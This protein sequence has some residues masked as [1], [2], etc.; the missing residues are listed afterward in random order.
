MKNMVVDDRLGIPDTSADPGSRLLRGEEVAQILNCSRAFAFRLM[1][2]GKIRTVRM[3]RAVR[4]RKQDLEAFIL[5][6]TQ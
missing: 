3:G 2:Q 4:V 1:R 6:N 5:G